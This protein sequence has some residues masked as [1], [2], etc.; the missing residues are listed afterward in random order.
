MILIFILAL[1]SL[2]IHQTAPSFVKISERGGCLY[3]MI[4]YF[5]LIE[6]LFNELP[7]CE[8]PHPGLLHL[9]Y[10]LRIP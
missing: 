4:K 6:I 10:P 9:R 3:Y 5:C 1:P 8:H 2:S 7:Q